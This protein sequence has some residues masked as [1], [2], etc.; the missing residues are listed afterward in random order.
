[1]RGRAPSGAPRSGMFA[2]IADR[3]K[4]SLWLP[5]YTIVSACNL[6]VVEL[7]DPCAARAT[8]KISIR[9]NLDPRRPARAPWNA[10]QPD[11]TS[12]FGHTSY[13][14]ADEAQEVTFYYLTVCGSVRQYHVLD[15]TGSERGSGELEFNEHGDLKRVTQLVPLR[16]VSRDGTIGQPITIDYG[17]LSPA[18]GQ[19]SSTSIEPYDTILSIEQDGYE[20]GSGP[21]CL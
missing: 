6:P 19:S 11:D 17:A 13:A 5:L 4:R 3:M 9:V 21:E 7:E 10:A 2:A 18:A 16:L 15:P 20:A 1:M 14:Y 12:D 8:S